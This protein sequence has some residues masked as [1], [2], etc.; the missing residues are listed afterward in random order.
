MMPDFGGDASA[1]PWILV[2]MPV[3]YLD[4]GGDASDF[5]INIP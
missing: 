5:V 3:L 1:T 4:C 2:V